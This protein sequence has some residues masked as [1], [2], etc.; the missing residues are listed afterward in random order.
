MPSPEF[1]VSGRDRQRGLTLVELLVAMTVGLMVVVAALGA[2]TLSRAASG[3]VSDL[4]Q[5]QQ[6]GSYALHVIGTQFRSAGSVDPVQDDAT[7]LFAFGEPAGVG[8]VNTT[9]FGVEGGT[10]PDSV[11]VAFAPASTGT[12]DPRLSAQYDC[13]GTRMNEGDRVI[14]TFEVSAQGQLRCAGISQ[15]E[16]VIANVADLQVNYRVE[17]EG[18][19]QIMDADAV[20]GRKLW[21][22][23]TAIE[24]CLDL[25]GDERS[26]DFDDLYKACGNTDRRRDGRVHLVFRNVF[27]LRT[28]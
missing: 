10:A 6:Q 11:S 2:L 15:K 21:S 12:A 7:G 22:A 14:A 17:T 26:A 24:V 20:E 27:A 18:R 1:R 5:L 13:T 3:D 16:P 4:S 19:V 8:S 25:Q 23:V 9:V 28:H